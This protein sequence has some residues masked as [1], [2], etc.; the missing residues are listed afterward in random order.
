MVQNRI[1]DEEL[2]SKGIKPPTIINDVAVNGDAIVSGRL[3]SQDNYLSDL[4]IEAAVLPS[5]F[6]EVDRVR[7]VPKF[8][9]TN[10]N[11]IGY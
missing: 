11:R 7:K 5:F 3:V 9:G 4:Q 2:N 1:V 8:Y 10:C 6:V